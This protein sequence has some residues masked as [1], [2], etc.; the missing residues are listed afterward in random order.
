[1]S[2]YTLIIDFDGGTYV[3][4]AMSGEIENAPSECIKAWNINDIKNTITEEDKVNILN[5]LKEEEFVQLRGIKNV[6]CGSVSLR[7]ISLTLN[8]VLTKNAT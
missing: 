1:M 2:I 7:K 5:Q 6:W 3:T 8:L 4:Q